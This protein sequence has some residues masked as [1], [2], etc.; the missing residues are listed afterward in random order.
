VEDGVIEQAPEER[1][2]ASKPASVYRFK[3][4]RAKKAKRH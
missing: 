4:L 1:L 2:T 3:R